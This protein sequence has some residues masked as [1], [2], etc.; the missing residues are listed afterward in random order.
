MEG[1]LAE[2]PAEEVGIVAGQRLTEIAG[3]PADLL[4]PLEIAA[5]MRG[6]AGSDVRLVVAD[7]GPHPHFHTIRLERRTLPQPPTKL[8]SSSCNTIRSSQQE[9]TYLKAHFKHLKSSY[10][11][12]LSQGRR[13]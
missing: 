4:S 11:S 9:A 6:P 12:K 2:S 7:P 1:P 8:V 5:L 10:T 3:Y 13:V